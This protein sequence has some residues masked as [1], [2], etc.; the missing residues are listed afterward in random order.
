MLTERVLS[1]FPEKKKLVGGSGMAG[2]ESSN[3]IVTKKIM[4]NLYI[5]GDGEAEA[6]PET[7]LWRREFQSVQD[8]RLI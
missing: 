2:F 5:C 7:V 3:R 4:K 1:D 8:I 6:G